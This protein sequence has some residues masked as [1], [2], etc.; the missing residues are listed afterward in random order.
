M[1]V[2]GKPRT[3]GMPAPTP[4]PEQSTPMLEAKEQ[5]AEE[6]AAM[7]EDAAVGGAEEAAADL[8]KSQVDTAQDSR[9]TCDCSGPE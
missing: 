9:D 7:A 8:F 5:P 3:R 4:V 6:Q 2:K 1:L